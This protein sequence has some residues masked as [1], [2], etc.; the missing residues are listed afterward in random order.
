MRTIE[1]RVDDV[2]DAIQALNIWHPEYLHCFRVVLKREP[3]ELPEWE[4]VVRCEEP[5]WGIEGM[6]IM[7]VYHA[8]YGDVLDS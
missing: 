7:D 2:C 1:A 3:E 4:A 8:V 5:E 6:E